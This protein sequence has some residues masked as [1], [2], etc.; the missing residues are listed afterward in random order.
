M[1]TFKDQLLARIRS[2]LG[3]L[4]AQARKDVLEN[5]VGLIESQLERYQRRLDYWFAKQWELEGL[6]I[7]HDQRTITF[8]DRTLRFT[9]RELQIVMVLASRSPAYLSAH[10]L[11]IQAWHDSRLPEETL[12]TYI[13][14]VRS[15]L[16]KL[17][18]GA[19]IKTEPRRGYALIF[20]K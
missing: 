18:A 11:L 3:A 13:A 16:A 4:P 8:R 17:D 5:D 14:K 2:Q 12:R 10:Q 15:K 1:I 20:E 6:R 9:K 19:A 7:D